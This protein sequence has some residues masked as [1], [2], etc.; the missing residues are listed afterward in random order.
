MINVVDTPNH[1]D[2]KPIWNLYTRVK[3]TGFS[4][5]E[6][7]SVYRDYGVIPKSSRDD[8]HNVAS[9][10]LSTY[11]L[12]EVG[13]LV[14]N[15][16]KAW[17][18]SF[19]ISEFEGIVSPAYFVFKSNHNSHNRYLHYLLRS[20]PYI[21][22]YNRISNGVRI[23]QWDLDPAQFRITEVPIPPLD[24]QLAIADFLDRELA[25]IDILISKQSLLVDTLTERRFSFISQTV[26][27]ITREQDFRDTGVE[28]L[29]LVPMNWNVSQLKHN[30]YLK[31]RVGWKGLTSDEFQEKSY[32]YLITGQDFENQTVKLSDCYQVDQE[33]YEDD[34]YIHLQEGDLLVTKDGS[35][36]KLALIKDLD[37]PACLNS[38]VFLVRPKKDYTTEFLYWV[39]SS[40]VFRNFIGITSYG[41]TIQHLYQNVFVKFSFAFPTI[42][43]QEKI[44]QEISLGVQKI[45]ELMNAANHSMQLLIARK[46][47]LISDAVT[48]KFDF[49]KAS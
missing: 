33:R 21:A 27:G 46:Q 11:Q 9:E 40:S 32:A 31:A 49:R 30:T 29:G 10:D 34:P 15:K 12:V 16:M 18:G 43:E 45:D 25:Q 44:C 39:L 42:K 36:G 47:T 37:K 4:N 7:L 3:R 13:D 5:Y 24:E 26:K 14:V 17:Q 22:H 38:G 35:I 19:A 41:S 8:N 2:R 28:W 20:A 6:L 23:G 1:W 48:G